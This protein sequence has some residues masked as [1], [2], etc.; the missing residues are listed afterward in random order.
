MSGPWEKF[1][2]TE[3]QGKPW[4]MFQDSAQNTQEQPSGGFIQGVGNLAA[5]AIR[6][7][8][9]IGATLIAPY[10]MAKDAL[11]GKGLSLESNRERRKGIDGGL[12]ELGA[13]P[14]SLMYQGGKLAGEIAGTLGAPGVMAKGAQAIGAAPQVVNALASGGFRLGANPATTM[15]G[16]AANAALRT[17]AGGAVGA[18]AAG[19][20]NPEDAGAGAVI[21]AALPGAVKAAGEAG[22]LIKSG[23]TNALGASTGTSAET[24][25]AA[26]N[27]G[28]SGSDDF[29]KNMRGQAEFDDVVTTAKQGLEK[30]RLDRAAQYRNGMAGVSNDKTVLDFAPIDDA[31]NR[32]ISIGKFKGVQTNKH[33]SGVVDEL[34]ETVSN[35]KTLNPAE[36]H[37]PEGL[38]AL[39]KA[40][41]DVRDSTQFGTPARKAADAVYNSVKNEITRQA[42]KYAEVMADYAKASQSLDEVTRALSLGD[43]AAKDTAIRKLQSLMRNNAQSNYGN[44]LSLASELEKAGGVEFMPAIAGQAMN[45]IMPRGMSGAIQ[46]AGATA[47]AGASLF[48]PQLLAG[49]AL[50]PFASPRMVG[51]M[52]HALG[53]ASG[54]TGRLA[55]SFAQIAPQSARQ[56]ADGSM[57]IAPVVTLASQ[58]D[59][60]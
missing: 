49:A 57:R 5:G 33:A 20:I 60:Q 44:R 2:T 59:R 30:M 34:A 35:W 58:K 27:A 24:V 25:R 23:V 19:M 37:T 10:D 38:D 41:G 48:Q 18:T 17:G 39:K 46:K 50:A 1:K 7:A 13:Q 32:V 4:E 6:G 45:S 42:P 43:K 29:I 47:L 12:E 21:G 28:K 8:G 9:S 31:M 26:F 36:Y 14:D 54:G 55:Q 56:L 40:V 15:T 51:E 53:R 22:K 52:A 3:P 11:A 16:K